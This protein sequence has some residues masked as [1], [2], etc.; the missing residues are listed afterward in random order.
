[1]RI[2]LSLPKK[3]KGASFASGANGSICGFV[4]AANGIPKNASKFQNMKIINID[5]QIA[6]RYNYIY[7]YIGKVKLFSQQM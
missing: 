4:D 6:A 5:I 2:A 3:E 7:I 1:M